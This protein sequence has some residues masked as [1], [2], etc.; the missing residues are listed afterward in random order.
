M[1]KNERRRR[2]AAAQIVK[3]GDCVIRLQEH[4]PL[5][6]SSYLSKRRISNDWRFMPAL[7]T[8]WMSYISVVRSKMILF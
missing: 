2:H 4:G 3:D 5:R 7:Q 6:I 1:M 8:T